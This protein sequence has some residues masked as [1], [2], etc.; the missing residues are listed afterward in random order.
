M[1]TR[2]VGSSACGSR[3]NGYWRRRRR[4]FVWLVLAV[5]ALAVP[6]HGFELRLAVD[7]LRVAH[8]TSRGRRHLQARRQW[9]GADSFA[10]LWA[11]CQ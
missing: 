9:W 4:A 11:V 6:S 2:C 8:G 1:W 5:G 3:S 7:A 10:S